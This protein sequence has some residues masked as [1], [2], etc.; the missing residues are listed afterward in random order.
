MSSVLT[1]AHRQ[2]VQYYSLLKD[3]SRHPRYSGE[4]RFPDYVEEY[5]NPLCGD[6]IKL[7]IKLSSDQTQI[8]EIK[9]DARGCVISV[10]S[11]DLMAE[12]LLGKTLSEANSISQQFFQMIFHKVK[13]AADLEKLNALSGVSQFP[14]KMKC[15]TLSWSV[16]DDFL[17]T[18]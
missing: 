8:E 18:R 7:M 4:I 9:H 14:L 5:Q 13:L 16:L 2:K 1:P 3:R 15:A 6:S 12:I 17:H 10:V 11:A